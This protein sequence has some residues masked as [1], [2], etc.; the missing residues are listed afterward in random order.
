MMFSDQYEERL[1]EKAP[2][3]LI[4]KSESRLKTTETKRRFGLKDGKPLPKLQT[5][6]YAEALFEALMHRFYEDP[7]MI[8]YGEENRD[9]GGVQRLPRIDGMPSLSPLVQLADFRGGD[10]WN[11]CRV[12]ALRRPRG[13][14]ADVLRFYGTCRRRNIQPDGKMAIH[15]RKRPSDADGVACICRI[16]IRSAA[17]ARLDLHR[18]TY[19]GF[20]SD[21]SRNRYDAKGML[22]LALRGTDPVVFFGKSTFVPRAGN[23]R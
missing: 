2:E 13:G 7:T 10:C 18:G 8:A 5:L 22:S 19:P 6:T 3:V 14:G 16:E 9:W 12:C 1:S 15:V 23:T 4:P 17:F 21:V 11:C 20:E